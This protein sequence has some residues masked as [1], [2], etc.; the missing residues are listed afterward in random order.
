MSKVMLAFGS[1]IVG[2][3][4]ASLILAGIDTSTLAQSSVVGGKA[5]PVLTALPS[6]VTMNGVVLSSAWLLDGINC[7]RCT[8]KNADLEYW[9]GP[10]RCENCSFNGAVRLRLKGAAL[11]AVFTTLWFKALAESGK[12]NNPRPKPPITTLTL[13]NAITTDFETPSATD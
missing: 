12:P 8:F 6:D 1:F 9:G 3:C 7:A 4:C 13:N 5:R 2:V 10:V 11:N